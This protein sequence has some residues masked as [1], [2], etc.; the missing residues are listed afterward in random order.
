MLWKSRQIGQTGFVAK[1]L[2]SGITVG[3]EKG[4]SL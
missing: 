4:L 2:A 3:L 1:S